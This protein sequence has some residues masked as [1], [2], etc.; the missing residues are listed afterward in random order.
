[1]TNTHTIEFINNADIPVQISTF[2]EPI[3][4]ISFCETVI[5]PSNT[6]LTLESCTGEWEVDTYITD[7]AFVEE[8][9]RLRQCYGY[10]IGKFRNK[11][12]ASGDYSWIYHDDFELLY[13]NDTITLQLCSHNK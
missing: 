8:F 2:M 6:T 3:N 7:K 13:Q 1:M 10:Y 11:P 5:V 12:C 9:I 4:G